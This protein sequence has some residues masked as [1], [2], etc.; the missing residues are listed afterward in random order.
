MERDI[1]RKQREYEGEDGIKTLNQ[2]LIIIFVVKL[3]L[4]FLP[5][6]F[7]VL[8]SQALAA[9]SGVL[10]VPHQILTPFLGSLISAAHFLHGLCEIPQYKFC[11]TSSFFHH[12]FNQNSYI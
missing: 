1:T 2:T 11:L 5:I 12:L 8:L 9:S 10:K 4:V 7:S 3:T 6:I